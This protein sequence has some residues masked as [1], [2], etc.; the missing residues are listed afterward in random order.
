VRMTNR[1]WWSGVLACLGLSA[2]QLLGHDQARCDQSAATVRQAISLGDFESA[3]SWRDYTWKVCDERGIVAKLDK[4]IVDGETA[5]AAAQ[6]AAK[7]AARTLAQTRINAAQADWRQFDAKSSAER[8]RNALEE[9]RQSTKALS[10]GLTPDYAQKLDA[11]N[12]EQ[13]A[14][15]VKALP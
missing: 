9:T 3:R 10:Q 7:Q 15:R 13:Y 6:T 1:I 5:L 4:E 11:Y 12:S 8:T 14:Q 2:C